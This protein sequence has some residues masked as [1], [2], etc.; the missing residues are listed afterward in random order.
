MVVSNLFQ[1]KNKEKYD[2]DPAHTVKEICSIYLN[3]QTSD[4][5]CMA[6]VNEGRSFS[7]ELFQF[8]IN[9]L[10]KIGGG[11]LITEM[12]DF[13]EKIKKVETEQKYSDEA[14]LDPPEEFLDPILDM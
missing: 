13:D 4:E 10:V 5:F 6:V 1:V 9:T 12:V 3:L 8:A 2:F 7:K 11:D 14:L